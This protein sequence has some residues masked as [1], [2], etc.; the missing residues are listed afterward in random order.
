MPNPFLL[1]DEIDTISMALV[2]G[3]EYLS[4]YKIGAKVSS[5]P[6]IRTSSEA[7]Q[8]YRWNEYYGKKN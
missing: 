1:R 7:T 5:F 3:P 6:P 4:K 8:R 2:T